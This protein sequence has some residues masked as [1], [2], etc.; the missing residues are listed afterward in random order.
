MAEETA[1][2]TRCDQNRHMNNTY[3]ADIVCDHVPLERI[4]AHA[5]ARLAVVYHS[6]VPMGAFLYPAARADR[7]RTAGIL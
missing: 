1:F 3:Y 4:A 5:P 2:Y 7:G 6:E